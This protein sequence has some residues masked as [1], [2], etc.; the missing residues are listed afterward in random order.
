[1]NETTAEAEQNHTEVRERTCEGTDEQQPSDHGIVDDKSNVKIS[2]AMDDDGLYV[3]KFSIALDKVYAK[4]CYA[5]RKG[6]VVVGADE[7]TIPSLVNVSFDSIE[8]SILPPTSRNVTTVDCKNLEETQLVSNLQSHYVDFSNN[9]NGAVVDTT[10]RNIRNDNPSI[11]FK[12]DFPI[13]EDHSESFTTSFYSCRDQ[14]SVSDYIKSDVSF[15]T[16]RDN[17]GSSSAISS[18]RNFDENMSQQL[19]GFSEFLS[20]RAGEEP[21]SHLYDLSSSRVDDQISELDGSSL[22]SYHTCQKFNKQGLVGILKKGGVDNIDCNSGEKINGS[23]DILIKEV[24][25]TESSSS[26]DKATKKNQPT[27]QRKYICCIGF[28]ALILLIV[29][30]TGTVATIQKSSRSSEEMTKN[31]TGPSVPNETMVP[32]ESPLAPSIVPTFAPSRTSVVPRTTPSSSTNEIPMA[33]SR[34]PSIQPTTSRHRDDIFLRPK[35]KKSTI[36]WPNLDW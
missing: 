15:H 29:V 36:K 4:S 23:L 3:H 22:Q 13:I 25:I 14:A 12:Q 18:E 35:M 9:D 26:H 33:S 11:P 19:N 17:H 27:T 6:D 32:V 8:N 20:C 24:A 5:E 2:Q 21:S 34:T 28:I 31:E 30:T 1:M 10:L 7:S 16:A